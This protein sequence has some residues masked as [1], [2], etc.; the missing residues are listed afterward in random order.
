MFSLVMLGRGDRADVD[1]H[2]GLLFH[3][4]STLV[5]N[6]LIAASVLI[7]IAA[8]YAFDHSGSIP[9]AHPREA[10]PR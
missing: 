6:Y 7:G 5:R 10:V 4:W 9:L 2:A 8:L 1:F 3:G